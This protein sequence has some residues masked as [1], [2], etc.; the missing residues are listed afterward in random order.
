MR[1]EVGY[2]DNPDSFASG[3]QAAT[4]ALSKAGLTKPCDFVLLFC[5]ARHD[6]QSLRDGVV[7]VVGQTQPIYG[8]GAVGIIT[9]DRFGYAGDQVGVACF[10]LEDSSCTVLVEK[11]LDQGEKQTGIRLGKRLSDAGVTPSSPMLLFY[12]AINRTD[13]DVR[14][15]MATWL[16]EGLEQGL[17]FPPD[18]NGAGIQGD[19]ACSITRQYTGEGLE[20]HSVISM[21]FSD[22][23]RMDSII[24][25][26]CRPA[27]PYYTVT[28]AE[29][30]AILEINGKPALQF[31]DE[32][33]NSAI[34]PENYPFF[35]LFGL[36]HGERWGEYKED[37]YAS[38][39]CLDI[40]KERGAIIM[41]EPDM[42]EG[43]EFRLMYRSLELDYMIPRIETVFSRLNGR[44]PVFAVYIDCAGRCAG[45]GGIDI[46]DA[47][48]VQ[49]IVRD[50]VPLLGLYTGAEISSIGGR[51][52]GLDWTGV[53]CVFSKDRTGNAVVPGKENEVRWEADAVHA[54]K[55]RDIPLEAVL[56][57]CEQ[58]ASKILELDT[59]SI[60]IRHELEH[61]RRGFSLLAELSV[62]LRQ[63]AAKED[64]FLLA[65]QRINAA[66]NMQRTAVLLLNG[67][68][69][70]VPHVLQ[71]YGTREKEVIAVQT[72]ELDKEFLDPEKA[73]L[74]TAADDPGRFAVL[75]ETLKLPYFISV[76]V[77]IENEVVA[78]L[79]TGRMEEMPPFLSRLGN[80][81][82][83]TLQAIS[84]LLATVWVYRRL[85]DATK[86]AQSDGLTGLLNRG[87][88]EMRAREILQRS[89]SDGH[90]VML[91][92]IDCD[93]FK[94]V[95][96]TYGHLTGDKV[97]VALADS[98]REN[99]RQ[100]DLVSRIGGDEFAICCRI[101]AGET[102]VI[103]KIARLAEIWS[104]TPF[105]TGEGKTINSTLSV[106]IAIAPA[107]GT[108]YDELF[109]HADIALYKAKQ[110]GRNRYAIYE[111]TDNDDPSSLVQ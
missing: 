92:I 67:E 55:S 64:I 110:Q 50:R 30:S 106:G 86:Q 83:E 66:L 45:Y 18:V 57:L 38:R 62:S 33:L 77:V 95:N 91:V 109:H 35:L 60:A 1:V 89:L 98:L 80:S 74:V 37:D 58:N 47:R 79:V 51:P 29:G 78:I 61:K 75:R 7:S 44:E 101:S 39:L 40:D 32:L 11:G 4:E 15:L 85:G 16:I 87:A 97:L 24:V 41:F 104:K 49:D 21:V 34:A 19:H 54:D 108:A 72:F 26:G 42:T 25:H 102:V 69:Q 36:N 46:E 59:R 6:Q 93:H 23:I 52:R 2:S 71:G 84:S 65:T 63:G 20:R 88:F 31:M 22:D 43:T 48:V 3:K 14:L 28:K 94:L 111:A 9:N 99:F 53:F 27:S 68:R 12:D 90:G 56:K 70:F 103:N 10:W 105:E 107:N 96:D 76:P 82:V 13:G 8:G 73:V 17:G 100:D 5:T 81:D